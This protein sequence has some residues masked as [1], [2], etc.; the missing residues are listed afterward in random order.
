MLSIIYTYINH[1]SKWYL[2][3]NYYLVGIGGYL[4]GSYIGTRRAIIKT[5]DAKLNLSYHIRIFVFAFLYILFV[6]SDGIYL[7]NIYYVT[8]VINFVH[9]PIRI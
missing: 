3:E 7:L 6:F 5:H 2:N 8:V 1:K 4:L 9:V